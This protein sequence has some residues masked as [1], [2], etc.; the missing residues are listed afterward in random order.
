MSKFRSNLFL[1][2]LPAAIRS[3]I[4]AVSETVPL[5]IRTLIYS[6]DE[7]P[8]YV[9]FLTFGIASIVAMM[10]TG[11]GVEVGIVGREGIPEALLLLGPSGPVNQCF[12]QVA[13]AAMRVNFAQ[14]QQH[15]YP[16][17]EVHR[18]LLRQVQTS[19]MTTSQIAACNRLHEVE[20]R[21]ARW[22]LMVADRVNE[23][24][25]YLTQ[26]FLA[27]MIGAR[28]STVTLAAATLKRS[29]IIDYNR[30]HIRI[31]DRAALEDAACECY[32]ILRSLL[33]ETNTSTSR[34]VSR[35]SGGSP[36]SADSAKSAASGKPDG[37]KR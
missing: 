25:F 34:H 8:K 30:G 27:E 6:P 32:P 9:H 20:E 33:E 35:I 17:P 12:I 22:M 29:G 11:E 7:P 31:L 26:E 2:D 1:D 15:F 37:R 19:V 36:R 13:G 28:R 10:S 16:L 24:E 18:A 3:E 5:P 21:L 23:S 14:F 4:L